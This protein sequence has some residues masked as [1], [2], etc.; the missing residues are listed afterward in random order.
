MRRSLAIGLSALL[1]AAVVLAGWKSHVQ[2]QALASASGAPAVPAAAP[3]P[4]VQTVRLLTGSAKFSFLKDPELE[5]LLAREGLKLELL[6]S[7]AFEA[8]VQQAASLDAA[9]PAGANA[10]Q[11]WAA[12]MKGASTHPVFSTPL[13][14]ASWRALMPVLE[15]SGL[16]RMAGPA[17]GRLD[18]ER[19]L[20]LMDAATRWNQLRGNEVFAVNRSL[21]INTPDLR[22]SNTGLLYIALLAWIRNGHEVPQQ[23]ES[24]ERLAE[25]LAPLIVRHGFQ[26]ATLAGPFEDYVGQGMGKA[27]LVLV[28][29]SQFVEFKRAGRLRDSHL[30]LYPQ[31]GLVLK[32]V[33]VARSAAGRRLGELLATHPQAQ[34][35][36]ARYG[37]RT[38]DPRV[39]E[40]AARDAGLDAPELLDLAELPSTAV[41]E[42]MNRVIVRKL[43]N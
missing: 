22:R 26:E 43:E 6:K 2:R 35:I 30:L 42:A 36:A 39:F 33:L 25:A 27:P 9:W 20:A 15:G 38:N 13:A 5:A 18:L 32:H 11:D 23:R 34:A 3:A 4:A 12:A 29:E 17:H 1:L 31:P 16:A 41:L 8:D 10:A 24:A 37:F 14:V 19:T 21:L 7:G 28:Y 40:Q